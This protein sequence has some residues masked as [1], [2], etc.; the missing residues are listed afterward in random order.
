[1]FSTLAEELQKESEV[2]VVR[3]EKRREESLS[4]CFWA[5]N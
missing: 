2:A 1:M 5:V 4:P 3:E